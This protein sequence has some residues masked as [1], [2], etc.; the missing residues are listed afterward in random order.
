MTPD[1]MEPV[2]GYRKWHIDGDVLISPVMEGCP[3]PV[4]APMT[5]WTHALRQIDRFYCYEGRESRRTMPTSAIQSYKA[6]VK[7]KTFPSL[8]QAFVGPLGDSSAGIYTFKRAMRSMF[9][10]YGLVRLGQSSFKLGVPRVPVAFGEIWMWGRIVEHEHGYRAEF[11]Y[12]RRLIGG[13]RRIKKVAARYEVA[14]VSFPR[15]TLERMWYHGRHWTTYQRIYR[16]AL[17][18][19]ITI[20]GALKNTFRDAL[21]RVRARAH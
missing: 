10:G 20:G 17:A 5:S 12:P 15:W 8:C 4:K 11:A 3:W 1:Y 2:L 7:T 18:P 16:G 13:G 19:A 21:S 6:D 14:Y 9:S